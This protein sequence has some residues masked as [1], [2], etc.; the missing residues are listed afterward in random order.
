MNASTRASERSWR[1]GISTSAGGRGSKLPHD[2]FERPSHCTFGPDGKT[3]EETLGIVA[4]TAEIDRA[5]HEQEY[6]G[7]RP[8]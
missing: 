1:H 3:V 6:A 4:R 7:D 2:G 8:S 5:E